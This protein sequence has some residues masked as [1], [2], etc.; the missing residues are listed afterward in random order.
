MGLG[1]HLMWTPIVKGLHDK[2]QKKIFIG[3]PGDG[4]IWENNPYITKD[5]NNSIHLDFSR[6]DLNYITH[7]TSDKMFWREEI[8]GHVIEF[9][10]DKLEIPI[11][12]FLKCELFFSGEEQKQIDVV[13]K[14]L[15]K[16]FII[17]EPHTK[18]S[19]SLNREYPFEK[20]QNIVDSVPKDIHVVQIG[21]KG[22]KLL[23]NVTNLTGV[24]TFRTACLL[25][26]YAKCFISTEGGL[27]HGATT[28]DTKSIVIFTAYSPF[29]FF[30]YPQN[31]NINT[32]NHS[33][34]GLRSFCQD[35]NDDVNEGLYEN[36]IIQ[37]LKKLL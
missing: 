17:I 8:K 29:N 13:L 23:D 14:H 5:K 28:V 19:W 26:K 30:K 37:E 4:M 34:C 15:K 32:A 18:K 11:P 2:H 24:L 1:G 3:S 35:C 7:E 10:C 22:S 36:Q 27:V 9:L 12:D 16:D 6:P 31:I 33:P 20:Y 21:V 25:M